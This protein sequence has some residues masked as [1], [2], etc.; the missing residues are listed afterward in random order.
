MGRRICGR[1]SVEWN[2]RGVVWQALL[3]TADA[4][5][6]RDTKVHCSTSQRLQKVSQMASLFRSAGACD[7]QKRSPY[8]S[9]LRHLEMYIDQV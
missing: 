3:T 5:G 6:L 2:V 1:C 8:A 4:P 9:R 7:W